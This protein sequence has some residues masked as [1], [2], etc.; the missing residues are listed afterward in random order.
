MADPKAITRKPVYGGLEAGGTK[1]ICAI[2]HGPREILAQARIAT[3][4]PEETIARTMDFFSSAMTQHGP[5]AGLGIAS[6]GPAQVRPDAADYGCIGETPKAGWSGIPLREAFLSLGAP[7]AFDTDV[8]GAGLGEARLG[9]GRGLGTFAYVTIGTGIGVGVINQG[10]PRL[11][12]SHYEMGHIY[13]LRGSDNFAGTCPFHGNCLEGLA[14]G[15][16]IVARWG[17]TLESLGPDHP[18][19]ALEAHYLAHLCVTLVHCHAPERIILGGGVMHAPGLLE[20]VRVKTQKLLGDY[21][22]PASGKTSLDDYIVAPKLG[23]Q[24]GISGALVMAMDAAR[25]KTV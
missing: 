23:D 7:I 13:P 14:S 4:R 11:G 15:P 6:F 10:R 9:A 24:A 22:G 19:S 5:L 2:G 18:A 16:A 12:S 25:I 3:T 1:C 8:N 17:T 21:P 20:M